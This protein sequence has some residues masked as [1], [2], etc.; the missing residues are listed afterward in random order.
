MFF[1]LIKLITS[2]QDD[3]LNFKVG[4]RELFA[5]LDF[6]ANDRPATEKLSKQ[7][8]DEDRFT[9]GEDE[10]SIDQSDNRETEKKGRQTTVEDRF[11]DG[12]D[13]R[14]IYQDDKRETEK[15]GRQ[16]TLEDR[17]TDKE[18]SFSGKR[19]GYQDNSKETEQKS[20]HTILGDKFI[21]GYQELLAILDFAANDRPATE[22]FS[23]Q[24]TD[25]DRLTDGED[26]KS[27]YQSDN[28]ETERKSKQITLEDK[29]TD[30]EE[31][32]SGKW[33]GYQNNKE[34]EKKS[35]QTTLKNK[36][37]EEEELCQIC[38]RSFP[39]A[40]ELHLHIRGS[41]FTSPGHRF[42]LFLSFISRIG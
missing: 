12:E 14:S 31:S 8:T 21:A 22:K 1:K 9:D 42:D 7:K 13:E 11:T 5:I 6:A 25:E 2:F 38:R 18:E 33:S 20:K 10:Q 41:H 36:C 15:K 19:S 4:Y 39:S 17:V 34:A 28:R 16:T 40:T 24:K 29:F 26:E 27:I 32:F 30:K 35:K 23:K 3:Y 37:T